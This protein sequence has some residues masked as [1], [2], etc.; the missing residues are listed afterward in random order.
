MAFAEHTDSDGR[1]RHAPPGHHVRVVA[2][3]NPLRGL[4][5]GDGEYLKAVVGEIGGPVL[6]A[7][8]SYGGPRLDRLL[9]PSECRNA[10]RNRLASQPPLVFICGPTSFVEAAAEN[11]FGLSYPLER[12]K[13][14]RFGGT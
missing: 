4:T 11:V 3:P 5:G 9:R 14:E 1:F 7:G 10:D 8:H 2:P 13:T 12:V 6:L